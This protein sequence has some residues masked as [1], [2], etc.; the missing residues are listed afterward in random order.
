MILIFVIVKCVGNE[1]TRIDDYFVMWNSRVTKKQ[2]SRYWF[3]TV[4]TLSNQA[5]GYLLCILTTFVIS[6]FIAGLLSWNNE[7]GCQISPWINMANTASFILISLLF[8]CCYTSYIT[9]KDK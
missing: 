1:E 4:Y 2:L 8:Y 7:V 6:C 5:I 9:F 3:I